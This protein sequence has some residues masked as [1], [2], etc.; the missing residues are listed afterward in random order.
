MKFKKANAGLVAAALMAMTSFSAQAVAQQRFVT[1]GT[2]G[3]PVCIM[4]SVERSA[5]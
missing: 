4:P 1:I 3:V 2:G 5:G